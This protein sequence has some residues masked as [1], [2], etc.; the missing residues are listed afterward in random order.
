MFDN[1][2]NLCS[3]KKITDTMVSSGNSI[4][5]N[6]VESYLSALTDSYI[7]YRAGRYDI[8]GKQYLKTGYKY[9]LADPGLRYYL[10][11]SHETD[12]GRILENVIFLELIRRRWEVSIGK[13]ENN[14]VDFIVQKGDRREYYQAALSVRDEATL[15]RELK[16]L[17]AIR[18]HYPKFLLTLDDDPPS[19][20]QGIRRINAL[21]WLL[22]G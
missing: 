5:V 10:L 18:D 13:I 2:G 15:E 12:M 17:F 3:V 19:D 22:D 7:L 16:P 21:D 4:S 11:G 9:Y 6:S 20:N 8:K 14:E 1:I